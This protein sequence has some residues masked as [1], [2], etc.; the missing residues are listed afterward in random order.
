M[1]QPAPADAPLFRLT[2]MDQ[3]P[4]VVALAAANLRGRDQLEAGVGAA[5]LA[6]RVRAD[7]FSLDQNLLVPHQAV[8]ADRAGGRDDGYVKEQAREGTA[9]SKFLHAGGDRHQADEPADEPGVALDQAAF[10]PARESEAADAVGGFHARAHD[11]LFR[12][13]PQREHAPR[14]GAKYASPA[15]GR[16]CPP[17]RDSRAA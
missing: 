13:Q 11:P 7:F 1:R 5:G 15:S 17:P 2:G 9:E 6:G 12:G 16:T 4:L 8:N 14:Q 3:A 10:V